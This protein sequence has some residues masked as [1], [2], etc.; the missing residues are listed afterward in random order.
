MQAAVASWDRANA[1]GVPLNLEGLPLALVGPVLLG[2]L[3]PPQ[4]ASART[5][6][7]AASAIG[8]RRRFMCLQRRKYR[9]GGYVGI[10]A[11]TRCN[12]RSGILDPLAH[13]SR[14]PSESSACEV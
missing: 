7:N 3:E 10:T 1:A 13:L 11:L 5:E 2:L 12:L 4:A 9:D 6:L 8:R 14:P